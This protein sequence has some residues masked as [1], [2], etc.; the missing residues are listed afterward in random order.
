MKQDTWNTIL[1]V[2][3][4]IGIILLCIG[5][6]K[7]AEKAAYVACELEHRQKET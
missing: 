2:L 3:T 7:L 6:A 1:S 5:S 4:M